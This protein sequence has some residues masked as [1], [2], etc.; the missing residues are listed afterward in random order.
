M[1]ASKRILAVVAFI[2]SALV[3]ACVDMPTE[4]QLQP[5]G[6]PGVTRQVAPSQLLD[7]AAGFDSLQLPNDT[8]SRK[9]LILV[10]G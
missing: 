3:T 2:A 1:S 4:P 9:G 6:D 7:D 10:G 8:L 5:V